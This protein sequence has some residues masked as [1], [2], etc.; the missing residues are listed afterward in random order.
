VYRQGEALNLTG[1]VVKG[2][3]EGIGEDEITITAANVSGFTAAAPGTKTLTVTSEKHMTSF[4][5]TVIALS[6][7]AV[8]RLPSKTIYEAGEALDITG[9]GVTGTFTDG[10]RDTMPVQ[11]SNISNYNPSSGGQQTLVVT[12]DGKITTFTVTVR[13]LLSIDVRRLPNKILYERGEP[14]NVEGL[15]ILGTYSDASTKILSGGAYSITGF[16]S[17]KPGEQTVFIT[18]EG[19][20]ARF[21]VTVL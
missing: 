16:D 17:A 1:L 19:K 18:L 5:V 14:L 20:T 10:S 3:W 21:T 6:S 4:V 8:T 2:K 9:I 12:I 7:I 11:L 13:V 15:I